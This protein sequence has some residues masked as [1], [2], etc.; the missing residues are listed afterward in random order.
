MSNAGAIS[1]DAY[2]AAIIESSDD[3]IIASDRDGLI[4]SWNRAA[5]R[6]LGYTKDEAL[7]QPIGS[8]FVDPRDRQRATEAPVQ[9]ESSLR[10]KDGQC[11]EVSLRASVLRDGNGD[12]LGESTIARDI[13]QQ[14]G[15]EVAARRLA[16]IV[17]SSDDAI[18][19]KDLNG[20]V[21]SWNGAAERMF[22][23][24]AEEMIGQSITKI[25]PTERLG[26]EDYVLGRI[27]AGL[28]VEH[29]ETVR[30]AKSGRLMD[31]SLTV[32]P[33]R[34]ADGVVVGASKIA[35]DVTEQNRLR[36]AH[37][38]A[39][40]AEN[41]RANEASRLKSAFVANMSHELRTPLNSIIGFA[42]LFAD[43]KFGPIAPKY[44]DF[45]RIM[46]RSSHH[47]LQ[48]VND[49]LD[50]AKVESGRI[51]LRPD[52]I[53]V[54]TIAEEARSTLLSVAEAR[55]IR[56]E[57][58]IEPDLDDVYLDPQRLK[59]VLYNFLSNA[60]KFSHDR[61]LVIVRVSADG[62]DRFRIEVIDRGIGI[63]AED[64]R[65]LFSDFQQ[66][67]VGTTKRYQGTGLGLAL[68]RRIVEAQGGKIGVSSDFG[69]GST[70][71]AILPRVAVARSADVSSAAEPAT[72][73]QEN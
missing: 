69:R 30:R 29:F 56:I 43:Q 7:G 65:L 41:R 14:R 47:L 39:L 18:V 44:A 49:V 20:I 12:V 19:S 54:Q 61:G 52:W 24:T 68:T 70:F 60:I 1:A 46:V 36:A 72:A 32:S 48:L 63:K 38:E 23:F 9:I 33:I 71:F 53:K 8:L 16:A 31:I 4:T 45:A 27:R 57:L 6:L 26:E 21:T 50:L 15:A 11:I 66:L 25:I 40:E 17:Q 37:R 5:E 3:A 13:T 34:N 59:Q 51:D 67:D 62:R 35:R 10:R 42:E 73:V 2:L 64:Q 55:D 58:E 22:E 28:A